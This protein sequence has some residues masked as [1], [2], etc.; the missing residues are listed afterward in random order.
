MNYVD[1]DV[2]NANG[3]EEGSDG[4]NAT[5]TWIKEKMAAWDNRYG[6]LEFFLRQ[7]KDKP[8]RVM[9]ASHEI[10]FSLYICRGINFCILEF[11]IANK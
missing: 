7:N 2:L 8:A 10:R 3:P 1:I 5:E 4:Q 6:S 11:A 9:Q